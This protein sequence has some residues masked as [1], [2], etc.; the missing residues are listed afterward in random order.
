[1]RTFTEKAARAWIRIARDIAIVFV[2]TFIA[3]HETLTSRDPNFYLLGFSAALYG[4]PVFLRL[5]EKLG[6]T[7]EDGK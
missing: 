2:A 5:D 6:G 4:V 3:I 1:M 7:S